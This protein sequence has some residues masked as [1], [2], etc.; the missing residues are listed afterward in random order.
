[1]RFQP[2]ADGCGRLLHV[3]QL[4]T[5][6]LILHDQLFPLQHCRKAAGSFQ[7]ERRI[8]R[9]FRLRLRRGLG[10]HSSLLCSTV[11]LCR[12]INLFRFFIQPCVQPAFADVFLQL[13]QHFFPV[14]VD[15]VGQ[16]PNRK[17]LV[18]VGGVRKVGELPQL[19]PGL[20]PGRTAGRHPA[21]AR[22]G[23]GQH[24]A[25]DAQRVVGGVHEGVRARH[26]H[27]AVLHSRHH[28]VRRHNAQPNEA[29]Q[30]SQPE[31]HH[32]GDAHGQQGCTAVLALFAVRTQQ[33]YGGLLP[34]QAK[35]LPGPLGHP[36]GIGIRSA[37]V[38]G[39]LCIPVGGASVPLPESLCGLPDAVVG[40][41]DGGLAHIPRPVADVHAPA[42]KA[43]GKGV[44]HGVAKGAQL[45]LQLLLHLTA[46]VL[47]PVVVFTIVHQ[48][49]L[50]LLPVH[51]G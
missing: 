48:N 10:S 7:I 9:R 34:F 31:D 6:L 17:A 12:Q 38:R 29:A 49:L 50:T 46:L 2:I 20:H 27:T 35:N 44:G 5:P 14:L 28:N 42:L 30:R 43:M 25:D 47:D 26:Q 11:I 22:R 18:V 33:V 19:L 13:L 1:M 51:T 32:E 24:A 40:C 16:H 37:F 45:V 15:E 8:V 41:M 39:L 36:G 3:F 21:K 23:K 4:I